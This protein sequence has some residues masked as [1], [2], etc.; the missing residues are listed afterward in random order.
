[1][2]DPFQ[3]SVGR[4][5]GRTTVLRLSG[6]LDAKSAPVLLERAAAIR[7]NGQNLV[8]NLADVS[9]IGSSGVGA[10]LVVA[11]QFQEQGG[12]MRLTSLSEAADSVIRLLNLDRYLTID[13]NEEESLAAVGS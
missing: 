11:E 8:M 4:T 2:H 1:M 3:V 10:I 12:I 5:Q 6:S 13:T 7:A 9:F